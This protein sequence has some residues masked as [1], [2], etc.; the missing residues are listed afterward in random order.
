MQQPITYLYL[1]LETSVSGDGDPFPWITGNAPH[2]A[3]VAYDNQPVYVHL[4]D[5]VSPALVLPPFKV[6]VGHN[7]KFDLAHIAKAPSSIVVDGPDGTRIPLMDYIRD[8][9]VVW[10][11]A[12][13][14]YMIHAMQHKFPS[15]E[16]SCHRFATPYKKGI[17]LGVELPAYGFDITKV[18]GLINYCADD[19][20]ATRSLAQAQLAHDFVT[21]RMPWM[22]G[23]MQALLATCEIEA[24]GIHVDLTLLMQKGVKL[25][26]D[27]EILEDDLRALTEK[28]HGADVARAINFDSP[29]QMSRLFFGGEFDTVSK[30]PNG[31]FASGK[32]AGQIKLKNVTTT[33]KLAPL[34]DPSLKLDRRSD[35]ISVVSTADDVLAKIIIGEAGTVLVQ[36]VDELA[37]YLRKYRECMKIHGTY[38]GNLAKYSYPDDKGKFLIHPQ[39]NMTATSTGRTSSTKPNMQNNPTND[40]VNMRQVFNSRFGACG[41]MVEIDFKQVEVLALAHLSDDTAL[42]DDIVSGR[43]IHEQTGRMVFGHKMTKEQRRTTKTINFGLIY[44]GSAATLAEQ[45]GVPV[46]IAQRCIAAFYKRYPGTSDYFNDVFQ[47]VQGAL[48][49]DGRAAGWENAVM[50]RAVDMESLTG[51][52]YHYR[53][54]LNSRTKA[55]DAPYTQTRNYP[56]Q[57]LATADMVL[58]IMGVLWRKL[59]KKYKGKVFMC[60]LIH[61]S[62]VFDCD[63]TFADEFIAEAQKILCNAGKE[64]NKVCPRLNWELPIKVE[65]SRGPSL[66]DMVAQ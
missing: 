29:I 62:L 66:G 17:D 38:V 44:G 43:D 30:V 45:A 53:E 13:A 24:N 42:I 64:L 19:V 58:N 16:D 5:G 10:D 54:Q 56:I 39:I 65:V 23:M 59:L 11:T 6:L 28:F 3:G 63:S 26:G 8:H 52:K 7:I 34:I 47:D 61:D 41:E 1:D 60:G 46:V 9:A 25:Q 15:L 32:R 37:T 55:P 27:I 35:D 33:H 31:V 51:R 21:T 50:L 20:N 49:K 18:P 40:P 57:G 4:F 14:D 36:G 22:L 2:L 12:L 48:K